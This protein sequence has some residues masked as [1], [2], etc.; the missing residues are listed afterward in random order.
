MG[1]EPQIREIV[2]RCDM[3]P[4]GIRQTL[5]FSATFPKEIQMLARDFLDNYIFLAVGRVGSTSENITQKVVWVE[6]GDKR[7]F[8][9]DLLQASGADSLTLVFVETKRGADCLED[10]LRGEGYQCSSIHGDRNQRDREQALSLFRRGE[11][12]VLVATAVAARGLDIPN[13]KHVINFDMPGDIEEYVHRIGRTGRV[14]HTGLAT[15]FVHDK[16]RNIARDLG[17]ILRE[18]KQEIPTW[19]ESMGYHA[20]QHQ[21]AK[22]AQKG[23]YGGGGGGGFGARDY[24]Q[25]G[26]GRG[27]GGGHHHHQAGGNNYYQQQPQVYAANSYSGFNSYSQQP[28]V[29]GGY[30]ATGNRGGA[31][32][33]GGSGGKSNDW[34]DK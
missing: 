8:L 6:E 2:E 3:P 31:P 27:G 9:L 21:A 11:T 13:V 17:D 25:F 30:R 34:W 18:A 20:Q 14:G 33:G 19:L 32:R 28:A 7:S 15:S 1:F 22:R 10:Y 23:R 5:M 24:R 4:T 12:P 26:G 29:Q 16:S